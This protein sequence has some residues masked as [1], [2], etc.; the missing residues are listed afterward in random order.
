MKILS[1]DLNKDY[2]DALIE[3]VNVLRF[4]GVVVYPTDTVYGLGA[5]ACDCYAV[6]LVFK[7]KN[8]PLSKPLPIIARNMKWVRELAFMP[9][10]LEK[11]LAEI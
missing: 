10:K 3:A 8:R 7:I 4:G 9:P 11:S 5:N 1:V 2:T 6:E